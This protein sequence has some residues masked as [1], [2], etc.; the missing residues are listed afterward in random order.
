MEKAINATDGASGTTKANVPIMETRGLVKR[1]GSFIANDGLNLTIRKGEIHAILGENGAGKSTLMNMLSGLLAPDEGEIYYNG[2]QVSFTSPRSAMEI[3][4]GM[5]HQHFMLVPALTVAENVVLG[6]KQRSPWFRLSAACAEIERLSASFGLDVDPRKRVADLSVGQQ[7]RVEIM[8]TLYRG[9]DFIIMDEP[10]AVLTPPEVQD[11]FRVLRALREQGKTIVFI[12]HKLQEVKAICDRVTVLRLGKHIASM[13]ME[14]TSP[15]ELARLMVGRDI[16]PPAVRQ[17]PGDG[18]KLLET[19]NLSAWHGGIQVIRDVTFDLREGE[20]L[21][22]AG[23]DGN[24]QRELCEALMGLGTKHAGSITVRGR[25]IEQPSPIAMI[26][27][28]VG[29]IPED[30]HREGLM[31][32]MSIGENL[33]AK[34]YRQSPFS[35]YRMLSRRAIR[36]AAMRA[37]QAFDIR[38]PAVDHPAGKLSGGNQQKVVLARELMLRPDILLAMQPTRG[39]DVGA[40][41]YVHRRLLEERERGCGILLI[42]TELEEI[43]AL[44]DRV[45]VMYKGRMLDIIDRRHADAEQ[46]GLRMAG[47]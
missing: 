18:A 28:G 5:V 45:A 8:K 17:P 20:I 23:V 43:L 36:D 11:L 13:P 7:Q 34:Q 25:S 10:T 41:E 40:A 29:Y 44:S 35:R 26:A 37:V 30:R 38:T 6:I 14:G 31:L 2:S 39:M 22:I 1:F 19:A 32:P 16:Q 21:G 42:S 4:I 15:S 27:S 47:L 33:I 24:G 3:G 46:I 9:A 12:S